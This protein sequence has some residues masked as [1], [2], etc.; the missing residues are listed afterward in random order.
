MSNSRILTIRKSATVNPQQIMLP[1]L[2]VNRQFGYSVDSIFRKI[3]SS[4]EVHLGTDITFPHTIEEYFW[5]QEGQQGK[6]PWIALGLLNNGIYFLF[7][8]FMIMPTGT[9]TNNGHMN[10]WASTR[11]SD[12]IQFAMDSPIY[13][14][15]LANTS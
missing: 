7:T 1:L 6:E 11:F 5:I 8:A 9:F 4:S 13:S 15:Y 10:L 14:L 3:F 12:I 2:F